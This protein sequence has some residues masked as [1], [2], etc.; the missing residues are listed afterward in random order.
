MRRWFVCLLVGLLLACALHAQ[1]YTGITGMIHV[2]TAEMAPEGDARIGVSFLNR[3]FLPDMIN[4]EGEKYDSFNHY[5]AITPF[6]WIE[7]A[8]VCTLVKDY[9]NLDKTQ[10][11]GYYQKD[12]FFAVKLR[13]L[14]EGRYLPAMAIGV[15]DLG[16]MFFVEDKGNVFFQNYYIAATKYWRPRGHEL[17]FHLTYRHYSSEDNRKWNGVVGGVTYR[18]AF[19]SN[20]RAM[21]EY[22]GNDLNV[23]VDCLLWKHL[24]IQAALQ[25]G[26]YFSGGLRFQM[27]LF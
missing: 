27:N 2:P 13:L 26:R 17:G 8:Y 20:C 15:Q 23:G 16:N 21:V 3:E 9:K 11:V 18:P 19:A 14:K 22:T 7:L 12:R 10:K 5:L 1:E 24:F 6:P 25:N 4:F